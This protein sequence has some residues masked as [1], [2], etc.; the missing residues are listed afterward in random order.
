[1]IR[2]IEGIDGGRYDEG[3][4][5]REGGEKKNKT[6]KNHMPLFCFVLFLFWQSVPLGGRVRVHHPSCVH[7]GAD[8]VQSTQRFLLHRRPA[9]RY[10]FLNPK[11]LG[12][13]SFHSLS[14]TCA[15]KRQWKKMGENKSNDER[16]SREN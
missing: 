1:M 8:R 6:Q 4:G 16:A 3:K 7:P 2:S 5:M 9:P 13:C 12:R 14:R 11:H 15:K 10:S